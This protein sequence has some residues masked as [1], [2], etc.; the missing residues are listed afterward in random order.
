MLALNK[1]KE[2][3]RLNIPDCESKCLDGAVFLPPVVPPVVFL[4]IWGSP[5]SFDVGGWTLQ[6]VTSLGN[7]SL[8]GRCVV[9][10]V[11]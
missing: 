6:R 11:R 3:T 8:L 7:V 5:F 4:G 1:R 10:G 2:N 9:Q